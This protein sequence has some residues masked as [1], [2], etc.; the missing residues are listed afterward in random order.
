MLAH[1]Q[2]EREAGDAAAHDRDAHAYVVPLFEHFNL[3][4]NVSAVRPNLLTEPRD[5]A[6]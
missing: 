5:N 1:R 6:R 2:R 3:T 4:A